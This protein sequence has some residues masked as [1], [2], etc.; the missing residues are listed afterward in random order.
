VWLHKAIFETLS[1]LA[2]KF[3]ENE[4]V[5]SSFDICHST[6]C[7]PTLLLP[8]AEH[9]YGNIIETVDDCMQDH[10]ALWK[11]T[12]T[13]ETNLP[14]SQEGGGDLPIQFGS[15]V[16]LALKLT[17]LVRETELTGMYRV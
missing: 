3:D 16:R 1:S 12:S 14:V 17:D 9:L 10:K 15:A 5:T 4:D 8:Y 13:S 7:E 6:D 11:D 2:S